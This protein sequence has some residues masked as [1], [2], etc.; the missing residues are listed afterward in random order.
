LL[1][2]STCPI[3]LPQNKKAVEDSSHTGCDVM[4]L[5][6]DRRAYSFSVQVLVQT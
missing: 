5:G 2:G 1:L 4:L 6:E 3:P